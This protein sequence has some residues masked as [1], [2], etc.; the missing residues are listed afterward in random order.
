MNAKC[1][2][3]NGI[4]EFGIDIGGAQG[5]IF[6]ETL[7]FAKGVGVEHAF[8]INT[9]GFTDTTFLANGGTIKISPIVGNI[10]IY[11]IEYQITRTY[12]S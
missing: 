12:K 1:A 11:D 3:N 9:N 7:L 2:H 4:F 8:S 5:I 6:K 10:T